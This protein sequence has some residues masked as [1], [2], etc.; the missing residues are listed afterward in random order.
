MAYATIADI[1]LYNANID[2]SNAVE[3]QRLLDRASEWVD[4]VITCPPTSCPETTLKMATL[5]IVET[6][7]AGTEMAQVVGAAGGGFSIGSFRMD[8]DATGGGISALPQRAVNALR[9][10]GCLNNRVG[11]Y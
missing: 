1:Q 11:W 9:L 7:A 5:A 4:S 3:T 2:V 8:K 6:Y 10:G